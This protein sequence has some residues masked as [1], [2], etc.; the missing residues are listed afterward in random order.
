[1]RDKLHII[2]VAPCFVDLG[3]ETGGVANVVRQISLLLRQKGHAV[4]LICS[5]MEL[6]KVVAEPLSFISPEGV[7]VHV[8]AQFPN[9]LIGPQCRVLK[10]LAGALSENK[11]QQIVAHV[12]TCFSSLTEIAMGFFSK[13]QIP[14]VF[15]PHGKLS[16][17]M[18]EK[19]RWSKLLW[20]KFIAQKHIKSANYIGL[21]A[22]TE[23]V[24]FPKL[25]LNNKSKI[26]PNGFLSVPDEE[27]LSSELPDKYILYLGY[28]DPRKQPDFL[29][30]AFAL[31]AASGSHKLL[32]V[33]PDVYKFGGVVRE[34]A[35]YFDV[36]DKVIFFG[37]AY[38]GAKWRILRG[39]VCLCLPSLGEG[40]PIVLCEALGAGLPSVYSNHCN[41]SEVATEGAGIELG[42]FSEQE[43]ADAIDRVVLD[44]VVH[45][46]M[47]AAA[48]RLSSSYTW[49][50]AVE[51]WESLY[52][53][54][55]RV[56]G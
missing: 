56:N 53:E 2:Q 38:G 23:A 10:V 21:L 26:I 33:G 16:P 27:H 32:L 42:D 12:H 13:H 45:A 6:G 1:M 11:T 51:K 7:A 15:S 39:A 52:Y 37:A 36:E 54:I 8:V 50:A 28:I 49:A 46:N 5:N 48:M 40:H 34:V 20:W 4:T 47:V 55:S 25:S 44:E 43:W 22:A 41:F 14:F 31:S 30:R 18:F 29:V 35:K 17:N 19:H 3:H 24:L 9:P